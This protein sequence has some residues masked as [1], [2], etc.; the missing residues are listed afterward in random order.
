MNGHAHKGARFVGGSTVENFMSFA[1]YFYSVSPK[2][3]VSKTGVAVSILFQPFGVHRAGQ[4]RFPGCSPLRF[5]HS[6]LMR[7]AGA[8]ISEKRNSRNNPPQARRCG[9]GGTL[10][11]AHALLSAA[12]WLA[13]RHHHHAAGWTDTVTPEGHV[14]RHCHSRGWNGVT[15]SPQTWPN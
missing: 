13:Q 5:A 9:G 2:T 10:V 11:G 1:K 3:G 7:S 6:A 4:C 12:S 14:N 8:D 15:L